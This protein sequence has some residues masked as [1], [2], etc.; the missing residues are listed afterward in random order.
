[1][2][3]RASS[4]F[5]MYAASPV[6]STFMLRSISGP[7][8]FIQQETFVVSPQVPVSEY[9]D[10]YG[11]LCQR[12]I[13]P[14]GTFTLESSVVAICDA[15]IDVDMNAPYTPIEDLPD[16]VLQ[17]LL[18][19]RY[20]ESD[21]VTELARIIVDG[22]L[23]GY[24]QVEAIRQWCHVNLT[25][26]YGSTNS[27]TSAMDVLLSKTGV[28]R[29]FTHVAIALCRNMDIPARMVVG[30]LHDLEPMDLHAWFE[31]YVGG[32]WYTFDSIMDRPVGGR[33]IMAYGRDA[34]DV[35][36]ASHFGYVELKKMEVKVT[37]DV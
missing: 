10:G 30:Y 23:P 35:A 8:Q 4:F 25:R 15:N 14:S 17:F 32:R 28:C 33:V 36:F 6:T 22:V 19:S 34:A 18:P 3:L 11:N 2:L 26:Q 7:S 13:I 29:D 12:I 5:E 1:M 16:H 31:A 24:A 37:R 27:S 9:V 21:K 20:C